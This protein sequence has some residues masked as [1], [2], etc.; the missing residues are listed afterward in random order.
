MAEQKESSVLFSLKELMSLE[1]D[2]IKQEE[3][4]RKRQEDAAVQARL[5]AERRQR[6]EEEARMRASDEA[7]RVSEQRTREESTR[8]DAIRQAEIERARLDAENAARTEQLR[9][10]QEHERQLHAMSQDKGKK[11]LQW[12]AIGSGVFLLIAIVGGGFAIKTSLDRQKALEDQLTSLNS[13]NDD[14]QK[15]L[16]SATTPEERQRL[17]AELQANQE[18]IK[19]LK[20]HPNN[21]PP[22]VTKPVVRTGGGGPAVKPNTGGTKPPCNCTPGDP[23]CSCL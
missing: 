11:K 9:H 17:E 1:E 16:G 13:S 5:D 12:I 22:T 23:L 21:P 4:E 15:K 8:L 20:D 19:N 14:L 10:Q 18:A 3:N 7:R 6:E 2:R